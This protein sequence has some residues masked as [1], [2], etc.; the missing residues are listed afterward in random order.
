MTNKLSLTAGTVLLVLAMCGCS[1][2]FD[3]RRSMDISEVL[4]PDVY[5]A[6]SKQDLA[7]STKPVC[8][9]VDHC[10]QAVESMRVRIVRFDEQSAA[11][12]YV[13]ASGGDAYQSDWFA[14]V[15]LAP[16]S[17]SK[18]ERSYVTSAVDGTWS[19]SPD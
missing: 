10:V 5:L 14:I 18:T 11:A 4:G 13:S 3:S 19:D 8:D 12:E 1:N 17:T 2:L 7:D 16:E 6:E 15:F 9:G